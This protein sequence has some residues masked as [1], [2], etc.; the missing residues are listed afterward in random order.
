ME[1]RWRMSACHLW[2]LP[3]AVL[4]E[5]EAG[6]RGTRRVQGHGCARDRS[7]AEH[8]MLAQASAGGG[9]VWRRSS[10]ALCLQP[11]LVQQ[12]RP[13]PVLASRSGQSSAAVISGS[14]QRRPTDAPRDPAL[15]PAPPQP[16]LPPSPVALAAAA[17]AGS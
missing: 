9:A 10:A 14:H 8:V 1:R 13:S 3:V 2:L 12:H 17:A 7:T 11:L 16:L 4:R 15:L 6:A 5:D